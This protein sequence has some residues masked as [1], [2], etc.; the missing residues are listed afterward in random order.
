MNEEFAIL[1]F[2]FGISVTTNLALAVG[3][4]RSARRVR[5]KRAL[6]CSKDS[7]SLSAGQNRGRCGSGLGARKEASTLYA[8][9]F[10][11]F[12]ASIRDIF[13]THG[14]GNSVSPYFSPNKSS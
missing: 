11:F 7:I 12:V 9:F 14:T 3:A 8:R 4:F 5:N 13:G 1:L 10:S 6:T 2:F